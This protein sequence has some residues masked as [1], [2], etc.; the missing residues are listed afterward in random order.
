MPSPFPGMDPYLERPS[1]WPSRHG[2]LIFEISDHL[3]AQLPDDYEVLAEETV[4]LHEPAAEERVL[5]A[6][7]DGGVALAGRS[8]SPLE[9]PSAV[10]TTPANRTRLSTEVERSY[11]RHLE[12]RTGDDDRVVTV[13]EL[14]S[15]AN[16]E[17]HR[18]EYLKKREDF[19]D[20]GVHF[21]QIDLLRGGGRRLLPSDV[22][23]PP[24]DYDAMLVRAETVD[25]DGADV[26]AREADLWYW[27]VRDELPR[28]PVPLDGD[29]PDVV[30]DLRAVLDAAYDA[31]RWSR[32]AYDHPPEPPLPDDDATWA[33]GLL[34]KPGVAAAAA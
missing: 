15:P 20:A 8:R 11:D 13:I 14:L 23:H 33:A 10:A 9:A 5:R 1:K 30:L 4:Y 24:H 28:L 6:R 16:K 32:R 17:R 26:P 22:E 12:I 18:D 7:V 25:C 19:I 2:K 29:D 34:K 3:V 31:G 21:L 27:T